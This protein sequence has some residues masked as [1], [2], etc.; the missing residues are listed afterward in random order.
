MNRRV[1]SQAVVIATGV[2]ST[3]AAR[4]SASRSATART[5]CSEPPF[6]RSLKTRGLTG[7]RTVF[8][9]PEADHVHTQL[10]VI[11]G[12]VGRQFPAVEIMLR[13]AKADLLTF[14]AFPVTH[15]KT[16]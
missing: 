10:D 6:L 3:A 12:M 2:A 8:A 15:W 1:V 14:A 11:A 9:Q 4:S 13:D 7:A 5:A 16:I